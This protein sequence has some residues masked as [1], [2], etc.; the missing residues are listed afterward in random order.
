MAS[1]D[2]ADRV[3]SRLEHVWNFDI[4]MIYKD[5]ASFH[6]VA[7]GWA[8]GCSPHGSHQ[9]AQHKFVLKNS[10]LISR[11]KSF[12]A[13]PAKCDVSQDC[14]QQRPSTILVFFCVHSVSVFAEQF[15]SAACW[16]LGCQTD[17]GATLG[18]RR[19]RESKVYRGRPGEW[20]DVGHLDKDIMCQGSERYI[21]WIRVEWMFL[22]KDQQIVDFTVG[23]RADSG[24][25]HWKVE[26]VQPG[27][28]STTFLQRT[29]SAA[30]PFLG[31]LVAIHWHFWTACAKATNQAASDLA[32]DRCWPSMS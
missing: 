28:R 21:P 1:Q 13:P 29:P 3:R 9:D 17:L 25:I 27:E 6:D 23:Y 12:V 26:D 32:N 31:G 2:T 8:V 4:R 22:I 16:S 11:V 19:P 10:I 5:I 24:G 30:R 7:S 20:E 14:A 15:C 18:E